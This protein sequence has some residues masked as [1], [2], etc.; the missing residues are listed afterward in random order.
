MCEALGQSPAPP[1]CV[2]AWISVRCV[3]AWTSVCM[4]CQGLALTTADS[5]LCWSTFFPSWQPPSVAAV[6]RWLEHVST[7]FYPQVDIQSVSCS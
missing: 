4:P 1:K 2:S 6:V 5:V 3:L 7:S